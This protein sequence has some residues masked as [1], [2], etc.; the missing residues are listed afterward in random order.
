MGFWREFH[1]PN[2]GFVLELYDR[3]RRNPESVDAATR[4]FFA[5]FTPPGDIRPASAPAALDKIV[6]TVR[7]AQG[8]R[9][10]GHRTARLD[11]LGSEPPG[12]PA[13]DPAT[14]GVTEADLRQL[15]ADLVGGPVA[16]RATNALEAILALRSVYSGTTGYG[17]AHIQA[18]EERDSGGPRSVPE[19]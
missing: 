4:A 17:Y 3:Y 10:Y 13:L 11:P 7:L 14:Y 15:P 19:P 18:P 12:D 5:R 9:A 16:E 1:G 8:I 2:A 6:G